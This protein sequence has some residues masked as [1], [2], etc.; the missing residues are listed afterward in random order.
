MVARKRRVPQLRGRY[1]HV[2][3]AGAID[4]VS[5]A[6]INRSA[7]KVEG[8][9]NHLRQNIEEVDDVARYQHLLTELVQPLRLA[10]PS[11]R[12]LRLPARPFRKLAGNDASHQKRQQSNPVARYPNGERQY[13]KKKE[14]VKRG[15]RQ[16]RQIDRVAQPPVCRHQKDPNHERHRHGRVVDVQPAEIDGYND[17]GG[18]RRHTVADD[19]ADDLALHSFILSLWAL[20][21]FRIRQQRARKS[22]W[23]KSRRRRRAAP[24]SSSSATHPAWARRTTC[25]AKRSGVASAARTS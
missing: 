25:S 22:G 7:G 9:G 2:I 8:R 3:R 10:L 19:T 16:D 6:Q 15:G 23:K 20:A 13:R 11:S 1:M 14:E 5:L 18:S 17:S 24:S 21:K 12:D 4:A